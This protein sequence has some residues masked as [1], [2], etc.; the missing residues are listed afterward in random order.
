MPSHSPDTSPAAIRPR[1]LN[2][3]QL[4]VFHAIMTTGSISGAALALHVSQPALS[5][6]LAHCEARL[7]YPLFERLGRR[8]QP[9]PEAQRLH[10]EARDL[11]R[12]LDRFNSLAQRIGHAGVDTLHLA[13]SAT[14][15]NTLIPQALQQLM[16]YSPQLRVDFRTATYDE[17]PE[18]LLSA[19]AD[20]GVSLVESNHPGL[21]SRLLGRQQLLCVLPPQHPLANRPLIDPLELCDTAWIGYPPDTPLGRLCSAALGIDASSASIQVRSPAIALSCV[22][23]GLGAAIVDA[24]CIPHLPRGDIV[25]RPLTSDVY[26]D[27][28]TITSARQPCSAA[29][30]QFIDALHVV[31][32]Q[33]NVSQA[34][35]PRTQSAGNA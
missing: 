18:Y 9:T 2:M 14:F 3:R 12:G 27:I 34:Q 13:C 24:S 19:Q 7:G 22:Q 11:Y 8:L 29:G 31:L 30:Q 26:S 1:A 15:A 10:E 28:W 23:T 25:V 6:A 4:E 16:R 33:L 17:L 5:R 21:K 20:V 35:P 32:K